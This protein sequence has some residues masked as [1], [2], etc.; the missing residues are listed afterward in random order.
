MG[1]LFSGKKTQAKIITDKFTNIKSYYLP[2]VIK[3]IRELKV[4]SE[5]NIEDNPKYKSMK[6][7][8]IE[9]LEKEK[10]ELKEKLKNFIPILE[11]LPKDE[12][13]KINDEVLVDLLILK[14]KMDFSLR[15]LEQEKLSIKQNRE[16]INQLN[17][18]IENIKEE[19]KTKPKNRQKDLEKAI[20]D[21]EKIYN[22]SFYGFILINFPENLE[23]ARLLE[24]KINNYSQ[25]IEGNKSEEDVLKENIMYAFDNEIQEKKSSI[26]ESTINYFFNFEIPQDKIFERLD[27]RKLDP[28]TEIIY[29]MI[30]NPPNEK[31]KKLMARLIDVT[32]PTHEK[33][34]E[35][36]AHFV[37]NYDK[38]T[39]FYLNFNLKKLTI[40]ADLSQEEINEKIYEKIKLIVNE[41]E[42]QLTTRNLQIDQSEE[43]GRKDSIQNLTEQSNREQD[44]SN[45]NN[46]SI[47]EPKTS[48]NNVK[49][50][51]YNLGNITVKASPLLKATLIDSLCIYNTIAQTM[52]EYSFHLQK[53]FNKKKVNDNSIG[54]VLMN[55]Q[56]EFIQFLS[57]PSRKR[58]IIKKFTNKLQAFYQEFKPINQHDLVVE[59]FNKDINKISK[60]VWEVI[61]ERKNESIEELKRITSTPFFDEEM[62][63]F[64]IKIERMFIIETEKF[65]SIIEILILLYYNNHENKFSIGGKTALKILKN[66]E[67]VEKAKEDDKGRINY[68]KLERIYKN[69]YIIIMQLYIYLKNAKKIKPVQINSSI[70]VHR[71]KRKNTGSNE[72]QIQ[73]N[74][75]T[76]D[77]DSNLEKAIKLEIS[78]Y[79]FKINYLFEYGYYKLGTIYAASRK[80]FNLMDLWIIQS[81]QYQNDAMNR[82]L[83]NLKE[84]IMKGKYNDYI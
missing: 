11:K 7:N 50:I 23:Q 71:K 59:E 24:F 74:K 51:S 5:E 28:Q 61:N 22:N 17:E 75:N 57:R 49:R 78:K 80:I 58:D 68:P 55:Y 32:E 84:S 30:F 47:Q 41:F 81:I 12:N 13:E 26:N 64:Y 52:D 44:S 20:Q 42:D 66:T 69:C 72:N 82:V 46:S 60:Q 77:S 34:E 29:H 9:Q 39:E 16:E 43:I 48:G 53:I 73:T 21:L 2:N 79:K 31:D 83:K 19:Q 56:N 8:Q 6:K 33:I 1:S 25:P 76:L 65:L 3:E 70:T 18:L 4:K 38:I 45:N 67:E 63:K 54:D 10:E 27:N 14:L 36:I 62:E 40:Q 35:S 15:D 37:Q